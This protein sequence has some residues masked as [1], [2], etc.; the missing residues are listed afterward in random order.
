MAEATGAHQSS[1][2]G[3]EHSQAPATLWSLADA[4]MRSG[5]PQAALEIYDRLLTLVPTHGGVWSN[6]GNALQDLGRASEALDSY[7][8]ALSLRPDFAEALNNRGN[9]LRTLKRFE[10]A[11]A[12]YERALQLNPDLPEAHNNRGLALRAL[13]RHELALGAF[14]RALS[15]R[16]QFVDALINRGNA[17]SDLAQPSG[18][19]ESYRAALRS[20]PNCPEAWSNHGNA[21]L[22][23]QRYPEALASY[24]RALQGLPNSPDILANRATVLQEMAEYGAAAKCLESLLQ[25]APAYDYALGNLLQTRLHMCAWA[26]YEQAVAQVLAELDQQRRTIHPFSMMTVSSSAAAQRRAA[27]LHAEGIVA[28]NTQPAS[29]PCRPGARGKLEKLRLAYVSAD[30][31]E[32]A[33]AYLMAGVFEQHERAQF[34][35]IAISLMPAERSAM[36]DRLG[37]AF[38]RFEDVSRRSDRDVAQMMRSLQIDIAV[39]LMGYTR[40]ARP[41]L[42]AQRAAPV[43]VNYLG[44]PGSLGVPFIDY[45]LADEFVI[46]AQA[47]S[48]YSEQVVYLPQCFQANDDQ[49]VIDAT[50]TRAQ[51]GLPERGLVLCCFNNSY[52]VNPPMFEIWMRLLRELPGSVLW[53]L[54]DREGARENLLRQAG[55]RGVPPQRLVFAGRLPY[56]QHLGRLRL[57]DLFLDTVP[58]NAGTTAS[59]AL[60]C[61]VPVLTCAGEAFAAR[62]AGS[63]LRAVD[64]P[65]LITYCLDDYAHAA[66]ELT[67]RPERLSELRARLARH[68]P[69]SPLMNTARFCRHLETAYRSMHER[70]M[71]GEA[72]AGFSVPLQH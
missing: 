65:D 30:F 70:A 40:K 57:A 29:L 13:N 16:P 35:T 6:R 42:F 49:C 33:M 68:L 9:A 17:L 8:R 31:R 71:R 28:N 11:L 41:G 38:D 15:L 27:Q 58:Y 54:G 25:L 12:S 56:S 55:A 20:D 1:A 62:M 36:G 53:L 5:R 72:P 14:E 10:A 43:Q 21:L 67:K 66:L 51:V 52:K 22:D 50:P 24:D 69:S 48:Y 37:A 47:R 61:G 26:D 45:I 3:P 23:L 59:D 63:L 46:P 44:Y 64:L 32:H 2:A 19:L 39:D 4:C 34:E 18:A 60:R 7:E